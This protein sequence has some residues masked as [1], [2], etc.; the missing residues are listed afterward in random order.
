MGRETSNRKTA[1]SKNSDEHER[2]HFR[3]ATHCLVVETR[4]T[5]RLR[6]SKFKELC[7]FMC[8]ALQVVEPQLTNDFLS[9]A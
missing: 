4:T 5:C 3:F 7:T 8:N 6:N 9:A 1:S 2:N